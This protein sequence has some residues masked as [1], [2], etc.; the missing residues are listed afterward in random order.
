MN[1][2]KLKD[3][4]NYLT[5]NNQLLKKKLKL[6][7]DE[8]PIPPK[9]KDVIDIEAINRFNK[10]NPRVDTTNLKPLSVKHSNIKQSNVSEPNE[11]VIQSAFDTATRDAQFEGYPAPSYDKFKSR[12]LKKNM[13]ADGGRIGYRDGE[14][15]ITVDD[16]IDEMIS[17]YKDYLNQG[18]K[19]DF[20]TFSNKYIPQNFADGGR[21]GFST[22]KLAGGIDSAVEENKNLEERIAEQQMI[23]NFNEA[24]QKRFEL[25][26]DLLK[27]PEGVL[28]D[29]PF[30]DQF[31]KGG[32]TIVPNM[33]HPDRY[34]KFGVGA[35][36]FDDGTIFYPDS[37][38]SGGEFIDRKTGETVDGPAEGAKP[39]D[40]KTVKAADGGRIG[41]KDGLGPNDQ[42]MGPVYTTNKIE[43]AAKEVV[44]RLI[45]LDGVDI[46][47]TDKI[48]MSLGPDLNR[49]EING[50]IE[51]I[52]RRIKLWWWH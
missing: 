30:M 11:G 47:L 15:V 32:A 18:G 39:V 14:G 20:K 4:F 46:P 29:P 23:K 8:I 3:I 6:G 37:G 33:S 52:R 5:S 34:N 44:K 27:S 25:R 9:R 12:Y 1:P 42:P 28:M 41:Y 22:G 31:P 48:S 43:D 51:Y 7:T 24:R 19:M 26:Q 10:A 36:V 35:I 13:K 17:F 45:K 49:T 50:V 16:K 2:Y 38:G 40:T 21:I